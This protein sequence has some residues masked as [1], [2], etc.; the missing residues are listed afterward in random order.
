MVVCVGETPCTS[1][2]C[3]GQCA[4][5]FVCSVCVWCVCA[6]VHVCVCVQWW[7]LPLLQTGRSRGFAFVYFKDVDDAMDV[8]DSVE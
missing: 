1:G 5:V 6:Y 2:R 8:S 3:V 4:C 7:C